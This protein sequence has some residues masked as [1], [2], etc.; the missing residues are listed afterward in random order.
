AGEAEAAEE[1]CT[2]YYRSRSGGSIGESRYRLPE[3]LEWMDLEIDSIRAVLGRCLARG[4]SLRGIDLA[5]S[6]GW[7]WVIRATTEGVHWLDAM[8]A[9]GPGNP[10]PQFWAYFQRGFL[11]VLKADAIASPPALERAVAMARALGQPA[12]LAQAL[13]MSSIAANLAGDRAAA[14]GS[15]EEAGAVSTDLHDFPA[16]ISVL[17]ARA[18]NGMFGGDIETVISAASEGARLSREVGDLYSLEMMLLNLGGTALLSAALGRAKEFY[19]EALTIARRIDDR[20]AEY[21][22]LDGLGCEAA[23]AGH[24]R[25]GAQ[26]IGAAETVRTEA[27]ARLLPFLAPLVAQAEKLAVAALGR[28]RFDDEVKVGRGLSREQA[29]RLALGEPAPAQAITTHAQDPDP[30]LLG[31][32]EAEIAQLISEGMSNRQIGARLFIS[33]RT[34]DSHVR[35]ILNKLGFN[36]RAQIASWI[37]STNEPHLPRLR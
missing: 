32:R 25:L 12:L 2:E 10:V 3:W 19:T 34:V 17:Q 14:A 28:S 23:A 6:V 26:L 36:S 37:G 11:A 4:D 1:R 31:K 22:L 9:S 16:H 13:S 5:T 29:I 21:A 18:L 27:G 24:P 7:Y 15:L 35:G 30:G 20:V 8:L 33:E